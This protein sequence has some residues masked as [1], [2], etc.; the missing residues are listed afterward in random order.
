MTSLI[1]ALGSSLLAEGA[2]RWDKIPLSPQNTLAIRA[3]VA[4]LSLAGTILTAWT[5]GELAALDWK[6]LLDQAG[7]AITSFVA[8]TG[9]YHFV[10]KDKK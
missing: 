8:A 4:V 10:L 7:S 5:T 3:V 9:I 1:V 2:K 6:V